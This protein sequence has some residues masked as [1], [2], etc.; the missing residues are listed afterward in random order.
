MEIPENRWKMKN[1]AY[2]N[3]IKKHPTAYRL[4]TGQLLS[5]YDFH[6]QYGFMLKPNEP[7]NEQ[8]HTVEEAKAIYD[9]LRREHYQIQSAKGGWRDDHNTLSAAI[10]SLISESTSTVVSV[11]RSSGQSTRLGRFNQIYF[12][13]PGTGKS[14]ALNEEAKEA[15]RGNAERVTFYAD[16][17][18]SQFVGSYKPVMDG[19]N[20]KYEFQPGP[21]TRVLVKALENKDIPYCLIIEELN[22]AEAAS[23][24][25]DLFQLLDRGPNGVS[26]YP[27]S[28]SEDFKKYLN[29]T[30]DGDK[31]DG[32]KGRDRLNKLV[33]ATMSPGSDSSGTDNTADAD[34]HDC[35]MIVIPNNM[36]IWATMNSADQGVFPLDTAFKRRWQFK[37][38]GLDDGEEALSD[39]G[40]NTWNRIRKA[41][42]KKLVELG[43]NEDKCMG[44]FFLNEEEQKRGNF[45]EAFRNKVIMYLF[46]DAA[47]YHNK[48]LFAKPTMTLG[49]LFDAWKGTKLEDKARAV[50]G[51]SITIKPL[52]GTASAEGEDSSVFKEQDDVENKGASEPDGAE[53][54]D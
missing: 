50:F 15:F 36:Y 10:G 12:G 30:F 14:H 48:E 21:F 37:Y 26:Q 31:N 9:V 8:I 45:D 39:E 47:K 49:E 17:L 28:I 7:L 42:N 46:E 27:V 24:F 19:A 3:D 34:G 51:D 22:R 1:P 6:S 4:K 54:D 33:R 5:E 43:V 16:Y 18:H 44:P 35:D 52:D 13:A 38:F 25:G 2:Q 23:V 11:P 53:G 41:I 32:E 20:I 40:R 29:D